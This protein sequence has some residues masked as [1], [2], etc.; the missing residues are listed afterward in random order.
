MRKS[1]AE[2]DWPR[3]PG[4]SSGSMQQGAG[5]LSTD[6]WVSRECGAWDPL[7][8]LDLAKCLVVVLQRV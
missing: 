2:M 7:Q 1:P 5:D 4:A 6:L 8:D 3:W